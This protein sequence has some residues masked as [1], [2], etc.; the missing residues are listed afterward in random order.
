M[1]GHF[2]FALHYNYILHYIRLQFS[3]SI[4]DV[5]K[6]LFPLQRFCNLCFASEQMLGNLH[7]KPTSLSGVLIQVKT[8]WSRLILKIRIFERKS[9][10]FLSSCLG[11]KCR[12]FEVWMFSGLYVFRFV[13]F[14]VYMG[15]SL[16]R[17]SGYQSGLAR[18]G[19][20]KK[21]PTFLDVS[22]KLFTILIPE[23]PLN[24]FFLTIFPEPTFWEGIIAIFSRWPCYVFCICLSTDKYEKYKS[25]GDQLHHIAI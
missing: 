4:L 14:E 17:F 21:L 5:W 8:G 9:N 18:H 24:F 12:Y 19:F 7:N 6:H 23:M 16:N 20:D 11:E 22:V 3:I 1:C 2:W 13:D 25:L 10:I 15:T